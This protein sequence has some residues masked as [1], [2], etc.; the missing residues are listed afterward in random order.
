MNLLSGAWG[1]L[2]PDTLGCADLR[3]P[4]RAAREHGARQ[5]PHPATAIQHRHLE[6]LHRQVFACTVVLRL[7]AACCAWHQR[8]ER[9]LCCCAP[10]REQQQ[11]AAAVASPASEA[12]AAHGGVDR[13]EHEG[14][15]CCQHLKTLQL[16]AP[17]TDAHCK[18]FLPSAAVL[19]DQ[20]VLRHGRIGGQSMTCMSF[21]T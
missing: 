16:C 21:R 12:Q 1:W 19:I 9:Q 3:H 17:L 2:E 4:S 5:Q 6:R 15:L 8:G 7:P 11:R 13:G 10:Y 18:G 14:K 20:L